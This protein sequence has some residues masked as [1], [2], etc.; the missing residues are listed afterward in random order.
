[1]QEFKNFKYSEIIL[2]DQCY[3]EYIQN[4]ILKMDRQPKMVSAH[5]VLNF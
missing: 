2:I 3:L 1:M 4:T 5:E